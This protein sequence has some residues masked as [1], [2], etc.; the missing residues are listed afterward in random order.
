MPDPA[1]ASRS[2]TVPVPFPYF[3]VL[4]ILMTLNFT[5]YTYGFLVFESWL[6]PVVLF[7]IIAVTVGM[8][9]VAIQLS[10]PFG[11]DEVT[12]T[13]H[14]SAVCAYTASANASTCCGAAC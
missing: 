11:T 4:N 2:G 7:V 12:H 13:S 9:E 10:N 5:L 3:H 14:V 1:L 6:T 8:R